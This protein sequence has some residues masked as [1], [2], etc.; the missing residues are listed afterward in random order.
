VIDALVED[1]APVRAI[2]AEH[3]GD[4]IAP[5]SPD[6]SELVSLQRASV[7]LGISTSR[8][9]RLADAG[10]IDSVRTAGGH[11]RFPVV[12]VRRFLAEQQLP[13]QVRHVDPPGEP[14]PVLARAFQQHGAQIAAAAGAALYRDGVKGWFA[15]EG[16]GAARESWATAIAQAAATGRYYLAFAA[17]RELLSV[18]DLHGCSLLERYSFVESAQRAVVRLLTRAGAHNDETVGARRL[19]VALGQAHLDGR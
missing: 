3:P 2:L 13:A 15:R 18:A 11:R 7:A 6:A 16:S 4:G 9:R 1:L 14:L 8:L 10:R 5:T 12:A 19:F 17:T